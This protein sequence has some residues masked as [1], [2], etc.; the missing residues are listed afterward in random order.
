MHPIREQLA[1]PFPRKERVES[2][3][4]KIQ[5][6]IRKIRAIQTDLRENQVHKID[7]QLS[8]IVE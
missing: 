7:D 8:L 5:E 1:L 4:E 3:V 6:I 2:E